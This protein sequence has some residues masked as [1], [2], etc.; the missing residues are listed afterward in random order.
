MVAGIDVNEDGTPTEGVPP[1]G[2]I[3]GPRGRSTRKVEI[4][5]VD[6][7]AGVRSSSSATS[8]HSSMVESLVKSVEKSGDAKAMLTQKVMSLE[9]EVLALKRR[10]GEG[11]EPEPE[12]EQTAK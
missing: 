5:T 7:L 1:Q 2:S 6:A 9:A 4:S 10:L 11:T 12:P 3:P 8:S